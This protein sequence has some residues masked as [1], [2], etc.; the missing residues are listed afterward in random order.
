[1]IPAVDRKGW[2]DQQNKQG[3]SVSEFSDVRR[4]NT[5]VEER[6]RWRGRKGKGQLELVPFVFSELFQTV[7]N[8]RILA[9]WTVMVPGTVVRVV[10]SYEA[11]SEWVPVSLDMRVDLPTEGNWRLSS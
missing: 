9:P 2:D 10:N 1:M 3:V 7:R 8:S 4:S 6:R 11:A 5:S